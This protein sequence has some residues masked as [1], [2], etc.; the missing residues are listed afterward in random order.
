MI[1]NL[2]VEQL[3]KA[4]AIKEQIEALEQE[5]SSLTGEAAPAVAPRR[6][7]PPGGKGG[8]SAAG[9]AR[10]A[11]A[12]RRRWAKQRGGSPVSAN[13]PKTKTKKRFS[14]AARAALSAA[15]KARWAKAKA[16]GKSRL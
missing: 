10:I 14:A 8:I 7:R 2:S 3:R 4:I 5:L 6:G 9:R 1:A 13:Q 15:A 12:Q 16:T 11:A